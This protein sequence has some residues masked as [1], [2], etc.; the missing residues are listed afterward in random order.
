M[1]K[2]YNIINTFFVM[3]C[4]T[5][6][7]SFDNKTENNI[8]SLTQINPI[9]IEIKNVMLEK[10]SVNRLYFTL[11]DIMDCYKL[12]IQ[13]T[14]IDFV[15][16]YRRSDCFTNLVSYNSSVSSV[17][18]VNNNIYNVIFT[19]LFLYKNDIILTFQ[20]NDKIEN[21]QEHNQKYSIIWDLPYL[22]FNKEYYTIIDKYDP[23]MD[24]FNSLFPFLDEYKQLF[25]SIFQ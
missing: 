19:E 8:V 10:T 13:D 20:T 15:I 17:F 3:L 2:L 25:Y 5:Y 22:S 16:D 12:D 7:I 6:N 18:R 11:S 4:V 1:K 24:N 21:I 14:N 9:Y 23:F